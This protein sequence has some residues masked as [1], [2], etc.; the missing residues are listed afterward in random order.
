[1]RE[2]IDDD[3]K[4][5]LWTAAKK[6]NEG[7]AAEYVQILK[8]VLAHSTNENLIKHKN[9]SVFDTVLE[10]GTME[11]VHVFLKNGVQL[12]DCGVSYPVHRAA[13]NSDVNILEHL[14][15][16]RLYDID[17]VDECGSTALFNAVLH[18]R[19]DCVR[20]LIEWGAD[21]EI[22]MDPK[23]DLETAGR[24]PLGQAVFQR[25]LKIVDLLLSFDA[26]INLDSG[27]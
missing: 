11:A 3:G 18:E 10:S 16:T 9:Y 1:M 25:N 24:S 8:L 26:K 4:N 20:M 17:A 23:S 2:K 12:V 7:K 15:E 14:L 19:L 6:W 21:V 22:P 27:R 13:A 5:I